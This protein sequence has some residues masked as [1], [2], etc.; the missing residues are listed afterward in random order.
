MK[1][2]SFK[3][4]TE[5]EEKIN[6]KCLRSDNGVEF[7]S[8]KFNEFCETHGIKML[9]SVAK[10]PQK[11][12]VEINNMTVQEAVRT[13]LNEA[14]LPDGY[15]REAIYTTVYVQNRGQ[16]RVNSD[17]SPY[18]IWFGRPTS[19]KYFRTF[20]SKCYIKR[21]A[22]NLGNFDSITDEGIFIG[23]SSAKGH[24]YATI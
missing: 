14:K 23:Y 24:T 20:G 21:D 10:N 13:M 6:I 15:W 19:V 17:K 12:L 7:T 9:F 22:G 11:N 5:N 18:E 1:F 3:A 16:L 4:L 2:K 8:N